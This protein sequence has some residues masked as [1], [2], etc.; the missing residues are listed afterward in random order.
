V[1]GYDYYEFQAIDRLLT[2]EEQRAVARLSSRVAPH[3]RQA[4]FVYHWSHFPADPRDIL[5]R[6]YDAF[7]YQSSWGSRRILFRFPW[8]AVDLRRAMD[9]NEPLIVEDYFTFS[10]EGEYCL[11]DV[12]FDEEGGGEWVEEPGSL[13]AMIGLR[14]DIVRGDYR[15]LYLA[16]LKVLEVEDLLDSVREPPVPPGLKALSPALRAFVDFLGLDAM[17]VQAAAEASGE[18]QAPPADWLRGAV[19]RLAE[20][21]RDAFLL[22]LARGEPHLSATLNRRLREIAPWPEAEAPRRRTVG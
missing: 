13:S 11:L 7:F 18:P 17:L 2:E 10:I 6:Y 9:Y 15:A 3:P 1:S 19:G 16:W 12:A 5:L 4:V 20:E 21:E 22:R 14:D 8:A